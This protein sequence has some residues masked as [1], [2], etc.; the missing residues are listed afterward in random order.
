MFVLRNTEPE[1]HQMIVVGRLKFNS[2]ATELYV[3]IT[4][5]AK[6]YQYYNLLPCGVKFAV[7]YTEP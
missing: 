1:E 5:V 4:I 2:N 3:S 6:N 7:R